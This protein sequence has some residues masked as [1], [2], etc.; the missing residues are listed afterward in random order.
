MSC[1]HQLL[2]SHELCAYGFTVMSWAGSPVWSSWLGQALNHVTQ[3]E[4]TGV[5]YCLHPVSACVC[6]YTRNLSVYVFT[7]LD[8]RKLGVSTEGSSIYIS[9]THSVSHSVKLLQ[10]STSDSHTHTH[11]HTHTHVSP[12]DCNLIDGVLQRTRR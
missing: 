8:M 10:F 5:H 6:V 4:C 11:T 12:T 7:V 9:C 2:D 1:L 3:M